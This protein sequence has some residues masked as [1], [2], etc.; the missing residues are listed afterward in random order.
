MDC[1]SRNLRRER[2]VAFKNGRAWRSDARPFCLARIVLAVTSRLAPC[3]VWSFFAIPSSD[4][5]R[6]S[7]C[8]FVGPGA[9][10]RVPGLQRHALRLVLSEIATMSSSFAPFCFKDATRR[11]SVAVGLPRLLPGRGRVALLKDCGK[12]A[13]SNANAKIPHRISQDSSLQLR[14]AVSKT[15]FLGTKKNICSR[16]PSFSRGSNNPG[17]NSRND[18]R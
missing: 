11:T 16:R 7:V 14:A 12:P 5:P 1:F 15:K 10:G 2:P 3:W 18:L 9:R 8:F 4:A 17:A 6:F 13:L